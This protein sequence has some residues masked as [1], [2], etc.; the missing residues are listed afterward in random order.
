MRLVNLDP[1]A[2][3]AHLVNLEN[4]ANLEQLENLVC[5]HPLRK[6]FTKG[7]VFA[8]ILGEMSRSSLKGGR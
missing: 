3:L 8:I 4:L 5:S 1:R 7:A 2:N 6:Y